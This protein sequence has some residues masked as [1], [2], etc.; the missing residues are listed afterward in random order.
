MMEKEKK[1]TKEKKV[2]LMIT[3]HDDLTHTKNC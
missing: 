2:D 1:T 3:Q